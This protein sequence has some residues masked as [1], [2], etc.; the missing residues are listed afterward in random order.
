MHKTLWHSWGFCISSSWLNLP[1]FLIFEGF[2][3][4]YLENFNLGMEFRFQ[5]KD[6]ISEKQ[7]WRAELWNFRCH[8]KICGFLSK[9]K[10]FASE[11]RCILL[12][13]LIQVYTQST[14]EAKF[15][16]TLLEMQLPIML[17]FAIYLLFSFLIGRLAAWVW[18]NWFSLK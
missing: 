10:T 13:K 12:K 4:L 14:L 18:K 7:C 8:F 6:R 9:Y 17:S 11:S 2:H 5:R 1:L 16:W 15:D 3:H